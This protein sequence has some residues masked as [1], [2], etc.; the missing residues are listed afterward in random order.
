MANSTNFVPLSAIW[1]AN[2]WQSRLRLA[3]NTPAL[4]YLWY[5]AVKYRRRPVY[6]TVRGVVKH[7]GWAYKFDPDHSD[8]P[9]QSSPAT[10]LTFAAPSWPAGALRY[11]TFTFYT[12]SQYSV[13]Q[14]PIFAA[15][16]P[17]LPTKTPL[18][19][20]TRVD[21]G[22]TGWLKIGEHGALPP[23]YGIYVAGHISN[24]TSPGNWIYVFYNRY[25]SAQLY[26]T[27]T[28]AFHYHDPPY[29]RDL[30]AGGPPYTYLYLPQ[31]FYWPG[32]FQLWINAQGQTLTTTEYG[33]W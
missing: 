11:F 27:T 14:T 21:T 6:K 30:Q 31:P 18:W 4:A 5:S 22:W 20:G 16:R 3:I 15:T 32:P 1:H 8:T 12:D 17:Q 7:C 25:E 29:V 33:Y 13:S 23:L 9:E 10:L 26:A 28:P 19:Q 24:P 2:P